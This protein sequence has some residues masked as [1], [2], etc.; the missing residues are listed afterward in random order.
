MHEDGGAAESGDGVWTE[1]LRR[2]RDLHDAGG[3]GHLQGPGEERGTAA[4][5]DEENVEQTH[6]LTTSCVISVFRF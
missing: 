3:R 6:L 5:S 4:R 2:S 1:R